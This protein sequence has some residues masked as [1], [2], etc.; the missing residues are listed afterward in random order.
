MVAG[1]TVFQDAGDGE[2]FDEAMPVA[3]RARNGAAALGRG[4][5]T[6]AVVAADDEKEVAGVI[7][8]ERKGLVDSMGELCATV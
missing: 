4:G 3:K 6:T 1:L 8:L 5:G 2:A 7:E